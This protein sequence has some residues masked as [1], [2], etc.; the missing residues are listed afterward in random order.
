MR[1]EVASTARPRAQEGDL[2]AEIVHLKR[3][4]IMGAATILFA[5]NG[6]H[7]CSMDLIAESLGVTKPFIYS[8]FEDK[9]DILMAIC[10]RGADLSLSTIA[11]AEGQAGTATE[12]LASFCRAL[13]GIVIDHGHFLAVYSREVGNLRPADRKEI[14]RTRAEIDER[15][16]RLIT[17]GARAGELE[18][19]DAAVTAASITGM[20]SFIW[21]WFRDG[22]SPPRE[23]VVE[24]VTDLALRMAGVPARRRRGVLSAAAPA[25]P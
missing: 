14:A 21:I 13:A 15:V 24:V 2:K 4:R 18:V 9:A 10:R 17:A 20:L 12:R 3:E 22:R 7:G 11:T 1:R 16:T 19:L 25:S 23:Q 5:R 6:F 8:H